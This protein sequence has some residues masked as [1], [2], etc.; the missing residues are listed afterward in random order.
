MLF[1]TAYRERKAAEAEARRVEREAERTHQALLLKTFLASLESIQEASAKESTSNAGALIEI[2]KGITAQAE[3]FGQWIKLFNT[4]SAPTTSTVT[5][6]DEY[7]AEQLANVK[8]G[9]PADIAALPEEFRLAW[10]LHNDP[11]LGL[12]NLGPVTP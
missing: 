11:N 1:L 7:Q 10:A 4:T 5:E 9:L 2:A 3:S 8:A 12:N 6:E